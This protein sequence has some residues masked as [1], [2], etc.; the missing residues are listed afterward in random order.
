LI[1]LPQK[2]N[3]IDSAINVANSNSLPSDYSLK[4]NS[5][6]FF[7]EAINFGFENIW[8]TH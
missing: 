6:S 2:A 7:N 4:M 1:V 5:M 8:E 3:P